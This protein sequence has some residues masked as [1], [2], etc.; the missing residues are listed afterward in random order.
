MSFE[1]M[2][3]AHPPIDRILLKNLARADDIDSPHKREWAR[4]NW[5]E[6]NA[7]AY[8]RLVAQ[9]SECL[10]DGEPMWHLERYWTVTAS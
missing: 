6:L 8:Y 1:A 9:L 7:Y 4:L 5:T 2:P 10:S 3:F